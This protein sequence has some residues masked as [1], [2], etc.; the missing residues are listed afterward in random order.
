MTLSVTLKRPRT[1]PLSLPCVANKPFLFHRF[2]KFS[3]CFRIK[4]YWT[5]MCLLCSETTLPE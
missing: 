5:K 3:F 1:K 4:K 2:V